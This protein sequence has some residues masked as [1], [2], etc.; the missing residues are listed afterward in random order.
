MAQSVRHFKRFHEVSHWGSRLT[1]YQRPTGKVRMVRS[2]N[3]TMRSSQ[4]SAGLEFSP[5]WRLDEN[6]MLSHCLCVTP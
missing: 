3:I 6:A 4:I 5:A 1:K 2:S